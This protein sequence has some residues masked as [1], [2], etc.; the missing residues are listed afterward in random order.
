MNHFS[1]RITYKNYTFE[2]THPAVPDWTIYCREYKPN[3]N[4][5]HYLISTPLGG[6]ALRARFKKLGLKGN[7][8]YSMKTLDSEYPIEYIAYLLKD[9][10]FVRKLP[11]AIQAEAVAH[12]NK[13]VQELEVRKAKK[14]SVITRLI[15]HLALTPH[16][17]DYYDI[18]NSILYSDV[19]KFL[20]KED[21]PIRRYSITQYV[22]TI[23]CLK[24][25]GVHDLAMSLAGRK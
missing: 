12:N 3:N 9:G 15:A 22:D 21:M 7:T 8:D 19:I 23:C 5:A 16:N 14:E 2:Q 6:H 18:C 25:N 20:L 24:G 1:L 4:H 17:K 13:V 10:D 11:S